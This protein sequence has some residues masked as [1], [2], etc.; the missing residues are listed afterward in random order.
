MSYAEIRRTRILWGSGIALLAVLLTL[1]LV[2]GHDAHFKHA[3]VTIDTW[4]LFY[5]IYGF[6]SCFLLLLL[7][8]TVG[9]MLLRKDSYYDGQ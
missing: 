5:P 7:A 2:L 6:L 8:R 3:D 1:D 9:I 4:P